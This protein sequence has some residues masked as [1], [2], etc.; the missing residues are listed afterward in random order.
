MTLSRPVRRQDKASKKRPVSRR[1]VVK[2]KPKTRQK[3][4]TQLRNR[5]DSVCSKIVRLRDGR[6]QQCGGTTALQ[7][8]HHVS[9]RY[10]YTRYWMENACAHCARCH[11]FFTHRPVQHEEFISA[12]IGESTLRIIKGCAL[13]GDK[14]GYKPD[15]EAIL[16]RL[17]KTLKAM[18]AAA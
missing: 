6:C 18:E 2:K 7:W 9:R 10:L 14:I 8:S 15:Y 13:Y 4:R 3:T 1:R 11:L 12:H 17:E 5:C 16:R